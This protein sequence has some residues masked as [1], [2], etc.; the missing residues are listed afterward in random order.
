MSSQ[1]GR[2]SGPTGREEILRRGS[3]GSPGTTGRVA[4]PGT[5]R[6]PSSRAGRAVDDAREQS[7]FEELDRA[8]KRFRSDLERVMA[9]AEDLTRS[10]RTR[11]GEARDAA[12]KQRDRAEAIIGNQAAQGVI[13]HASA[14]RQTATEL[15]PGAAA[16]GWRASTF[17]DSVPEPTLAP[18]TV[19]LG[20]FTLPAGTLT[21]E[22]VEVPWLIPL[23]DRGSVLLRSD[24]SAATDP[25]IVSLVTRL[26]A[27]TTPGQLLVT[28]YD[29]Q[30]RTVLS[31]FARLRTSGVLVPPITDRTGFEQ[32]L[33]ELTRVISSVAEQRG[34]R[35]DTV[36]ELNAGSGQP[37]APYRLVVVFDYPTGVSDQ[38]MEA[39]Q[40]LVTRGHTSGIHFLL[41]YSGTPS[42]DARFDPS[43]LEADTY[44]VAV[45]RD[46]RASVAETS[47]LQAVVQPPPPPE[48]VDSVVDRVH[49]QAATAAAPNVDFG[50]LLPPEARW[51]TW[52]SHERLEVTLGRSGTSTI[53]FNLGDRLEQLHNVL[54]GGAVG[55][56]KSN[57]LLVLLHDLATKYPPSELEM[58]LLDFKE[59]LEFSVLAPSAAVP[60]GLPHARVLG[61]ET[62]RL[63][64]LQMLRHLEQEFSRRADRFKAARAANISE[65]RRNDPTTPLPRILVVIDEFQVLLDGEDAIADES[66]RLLETLVRKGRAYGIHVVLASQTLSGISALV[67][68]EGAIFSQ[69]PVRLAL[70]TSAEESQ[71]VLSTGNRA[72]AA[73]RFRGQGILNTN[74]GTADDNQAVVIAR[75]DA[76]LLDRTRE[77][78]WSRRP[79]GHPEAFVF[80]GRDLAD[81]PTSLRSQDGAGDDPVAWLGLPVALTNQP[82]SFRFS[83]EPGRHLA[84]LGPGDSAGREVAG[85]LQ[86]IL[87]SVAR[88]SSR[89]ALF[90]LV[91]LLT[92]AQRNVVR[93]GS[94]AQMLERF[95]HQVQLHD[96]Q[97]FLDLL[98]GDIDELRTPQ[99][100][101]GAPQTYIVGLGMHNAMRLETSPGIGLDAPIDT[102]RKLVS[103]GP[104]E[105][106]H[107][108]GWWNSLKTFQRHI[109]GHY[110]I[111]G[112]WQ[113]LSL[114]QL[115]LD[116]LRDLVGH[117]SQW[118]PQADRLVQFDRRSGGSG[119]L[120]VPYG[121][122]GDDELGAVR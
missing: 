91:D 35:Y 6:R 56:G 113:G 107:M 40:R 84:L 96:L 38:A 73:L 3:S 110:E 83:A 23:L 119:E 89:G 98:A 68:K 90:H 48:V 114:L 87:I 41:Q 45:A 28:W 71:V 29:P 94:V 82:A 61:L 11:Q 53:G 19:R 33:E 115:P 31:P 75:A 21:N 88:S 7:L 16:A 105:R 106:V 17:L 50:E 1:D 65:L 112:L 4:R 54:I 47:T 99:T 44:M 52:L 57:A 18:S 92:P 93:V 43:A 34:G 76:D 121:P 51:W 49:S 66:V 80:N 122:L 8:S 10:A 118:S 108:I 86:A 20:S 36:G 78:L 72:A 77:L 15:A 103:D 27:A 25:A 62:D 101:N 22:R 117:T 12:A 95:G 70:K 120:V 64:G 58:Y 102:L 116:D 55:T 69:I 5:P 60:Y 39:L 111:Q 79:E 32:H 26:L 2:Y 59:G 85:T 109:D 81:L 74:Y 37:I 9:K 14:V 63:F 100:G 67:V 30:L 104:A 42:E 13:E 97:G 24:D 46:G